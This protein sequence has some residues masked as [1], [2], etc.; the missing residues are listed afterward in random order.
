M[1][2]D[3]PFLISVISKRVKIAE[4]ELDYLDELLGETF[5]RND[6]MIEK[7]N[8]LFEKII[9]FQKRISELDEENKAKEFSE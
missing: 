7:R 3:I 6:G 8:D 2:D 9:G 1:H 5:S 4:E